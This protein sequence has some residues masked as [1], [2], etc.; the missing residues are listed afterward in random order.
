MVSIPEISTC[1]KNIFDIPLSSECLSKFL[2]LPE[3]F[4]FPVSNHLTTNT[5]KSDR[6]KMFGSMAIKTVVNT[7]SKHNQYNQHSIS[8]QKYHTST[9]LPAKS[10]SDVMFCLQSYQG[11]GIDRSLVY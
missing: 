7:I 9:V 4:N 1:Y 10:D 6:R 2:K 8:K 3:I 11:L 5:A